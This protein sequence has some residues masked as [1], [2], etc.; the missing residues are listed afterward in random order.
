MSYYLIIDKYSK[1]IKKISLTRFLIKSQNLDYS[2]AKRDVDNIIEGK[3]VTYKFKTKSAL[4][5]FRE[6]ILEY[7]VLTSDTIA[8]GEQVKT[9][10]SAVHKK[11]SPIKK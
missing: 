1:E 6:A 2:E 3:P 5:A 4:N 7:G 10:A 8:Q 9:K 11:L